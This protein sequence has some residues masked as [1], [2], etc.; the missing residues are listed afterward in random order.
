M[1]EFTNFTNNVPPV[2]PMTAQNPTPEQ[3]Q[4]PTQNQ[5]PVQPVQM[6]V[7]N[8][9]EPPVQM[10]TYEHFE[11]VQNSVEQIEQEQE[12]K[13]YK[14]RKLCSDDIFP[15]ARIISKI[16]INR[17]REAFDPKE[18]KEIIKSLNREEGKDDSDNA[19]VSDDVTT[20]VGV[21]V[22]L[23]VLQI[24]LEHLSE[25]RSDIYLF[26]SGLSGMK[27]EEIASADITLLG[28]MLVDVIQKP[29]LGN[30]FKVVS[31]L[32]K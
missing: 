22:A 5:T 30:F 3:N 7:Q 1:A 27:P 18:I 2:N 9:V 17:F 32:L 12:Q 15:M 19:P 8:Q 25:C 26:L 21:T 24:I 14:L 13:P 4:V 16:G 28:E 6:P 23:S 10:P 11:D 29:E 31:K 20:S